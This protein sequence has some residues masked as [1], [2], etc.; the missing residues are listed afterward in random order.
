MAKM[1]GIDSLKLA[2]K[3]NS[4]WSTLL[5]NIPANNK[6]HFFTAALNQI[7]NDALN[8]LKVKFN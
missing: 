5:N 6:F 8:Q 4:E 3:K 2:A 1:E 7:E